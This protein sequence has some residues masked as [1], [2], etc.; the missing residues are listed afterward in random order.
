MQRI[1]R[2]QRE[3][4][5]CRLAVGAACVLL[6]LPLLHSLDTTGRWGD[7]GASDA[8]R[9]QERLLQR[10]EAAA[11]ASRAAAAV[12]ESAA[13]GELV[14]VGKPSAVRE[15]AAV[16]KSAAASAAAARDNAAAAVAS[17]ESAALPRGPM[18]VAVKGRSPAAVGS[19]ASAPAG[20]TAIARDPA[21]AGVA[22][23]PDAPAAA[24]AVA[25]A[26][27][28]PVKTPLASSRLHAFYYPWYG[29]RA[30]DGRW[31]HWDH[32][33][34]PHWDKKVAQRFPRGVHR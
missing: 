34:L 15:S 23:E 2:R 18:A 13:V 27:G 30:H 25:A 24:A 29:S 16:R 12:R 6:L 26:G 17:R 22:H 5:L 10:E 3:R 14:A 31:A 33:Q 9:L 1:A 28:L 32:P 4:L 19:K 8:Q 7:Y 21:A 11:A 20:L